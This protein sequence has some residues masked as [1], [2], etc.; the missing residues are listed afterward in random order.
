MA[1]YRSQVLICAGTGCHS[2]KS[3]EIIERFNEELKKH[4]LEDEVQIV[5][6]GCFGLCAAGPIVV[7]ST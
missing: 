1:Y 5:T 2:N 6:T 3:N 4:G 7:I